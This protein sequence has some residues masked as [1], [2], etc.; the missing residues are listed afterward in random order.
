MSDGLSVVALKMTIPVFGKY[1]SSLFVLYVLRNLLN[2]S[3][4]LSSILQYRAMRVL[5]SALFP[6]TLMFIITNAILVRNSNLFCTVAT[7]AKDGNG[8]F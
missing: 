3:S 1:F 5:A 7:T 8:I 4:T 2:L 6:Q